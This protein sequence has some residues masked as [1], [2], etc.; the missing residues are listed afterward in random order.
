M[1]LVR[2]AAVKFGN[3]IPP[4]WKRALKWRLMIPDMGASLELLRQKGFSPRRVLDIGGFVGAWTRTCKDVWPDAQVC[5]FEPQPDKQAGLQALARQLPGITLRSDLLSDVAGKEVTF[6]LAQS[7]SS[8]LPLL[9]RL[10]A[11]KIQLRTQTLAASIAGTAFA[12]PDLVKVDVQGAE[13]AVLEGGRDV[14][15]AAEVV[16]LE[17][18]LVEEYAGGPL[19]AEVIA[20][21]AA[22]GFRVHDICTIFRNAAS[23]SMNEADVIFVRE[24]SPLLDRR[25][26]RR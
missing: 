3:S 22:Q 17:I 2:T 9:D 23:Q 15:A 6:S 8:S 4:R 5:I 21:M 11:P 20:Y 16:M 26:Y 10:D 24:G 13:L 14:L 7:G 1:S 19:F 25:F 18:A 12:K